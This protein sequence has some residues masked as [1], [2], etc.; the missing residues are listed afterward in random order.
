MFQMFPFTN[1]SKS[2][3]DFDCRNKRSKRKKKIL[4][5]I[6]K[7]YSTVTKRDFRASKKKLSSIQKGRECK[8]FILVPLCYPSDRTTHQCLTHIVSY[9]LSIQIP[10]RKSFNHD[11]NVTVKDKQERYRVQARKKG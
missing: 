10:F 6:S 7:I 3:P 4:I 1:L 8:C 2:T 5:E 11:K 9:S